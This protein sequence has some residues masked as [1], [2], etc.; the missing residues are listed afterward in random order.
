MV[1]TL[2]ALEG[3]RGGSLV[4]MSLE[5]RKEDVKFSLFFFISMVLFFFTECFL[6]TILFFLS[7][8]IMVD[9]GES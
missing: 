7:D 5:L 6:R 8:C 1:K 4:D 9:E 2:V 3:S